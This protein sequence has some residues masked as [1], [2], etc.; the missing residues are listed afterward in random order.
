MSK[1]HSSPESAL[2][3]LLHDGMTIAAGDEAK[4]KAVNKNIFMVYSWSIGR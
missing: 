4:S 2:A 1:V 3:G